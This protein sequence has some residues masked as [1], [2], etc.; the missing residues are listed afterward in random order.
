MSLSK[1]QIRCLIIFILASIIIYSGTAFS[2]INI[3]N[4]YT[5]SAGNNKYEAKINAYHDAARRAFIL[6]ADKYDMLNPNLWSIPLGKI[7]SSII[8]IEPVDEIVLETTYSGNLNFSWNRYKFTKL[9]FENGNAKT[10]K[11]VLNYYVLPA[12]K[13]GKVFITKNPNNAWINS[14]FKSEKVLVKNGIKLANLDIPEENL[15]FEDL[16]KINYSKMANYLENR[17]VN[18]YLI[19]YAEFLTDL[20]DGRS[21]LKVTFKQLLPEGALIN[22]EKY[23]IKNK[24]DIEKTFDEVISKVL[25]MG[26]FKNE[27]AN[28]ILELGENE[29]V[30][31]DSLKKLIENADIKNDKDKSYNQVIMYL[32]KGDVFEPE[33]VINTLRSFKNISSVKVADYNKSGV[34]ITITYRSTF[35][36]LMR[37]MVE[38]SLTYRMRDLKYYLIEQ[39]KGI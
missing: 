33:R 11:N 6:L 35:E 21:Y 8:A 19:I 26:S 9:V 25:R 36:D 27:T 31:E 34:A 30:A 14:W 13:I 29:K 5:N 16:E 24:G 39:N 28:D 4:I 2:T 10:R 15:K 7:E 23:E 37:E 32:I 1:G 20:K 22:T 3:N 38:H 12:L 18:H 17:L